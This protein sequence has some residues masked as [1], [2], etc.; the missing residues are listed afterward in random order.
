MINPFKS[1]PVDTPAYVYETVALAGFYILPGLFLLT[2]ILMWCFRV[3][4]PPYFVFFCAYGTLGSFCMVIF[5]ANGP[6]SVFGGLLALVVCPIFQVVNLMKIWD[7][8]KRSVCHRIAQIVSIT[9]MVIL[10]GVLIW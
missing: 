10:A 6:I 1:A 2:C 4:K 7:L 5:F 8:A 3:K 9:S